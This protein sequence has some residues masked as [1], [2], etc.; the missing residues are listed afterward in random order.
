MKKALKDDFTTFPFLTKVADLAEMM[1]TSY[2]VRVCQEQ[3]R[4]QKERIE[5]QSATIKA[6][7]K[8]ADEGDDKEDEE[9]ESAPELSNDDKLQ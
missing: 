6:L 4:I 3:I 5:K 8:P 1:H 9:P 2:T 7:E